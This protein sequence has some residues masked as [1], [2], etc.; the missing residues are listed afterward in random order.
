MNTPKHSSCWC[1]DIQGLCQLKK[2]KEKEWNHR[3]EVLMEQI[4]LWTTKPTEKTIEV[5]QLFYSA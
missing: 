4:N 1:L 5:I 2:S 3:L